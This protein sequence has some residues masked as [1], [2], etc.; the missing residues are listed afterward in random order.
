[1]RTMLGQTLDYL[2]KECGLMAGEIKKL[3]PSLVKRKL[4]YAAIPA[5]MTGQYGRGADKCTGQWV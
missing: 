5:H 3:T 2:V 1:M 4:C